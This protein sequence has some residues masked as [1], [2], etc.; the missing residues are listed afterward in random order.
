MFL[1]PLDSASPISL[2]LD[3]SWGGVEVLLVLLVYKAASMPPSR[4]CWQPYHLFTIATTGKKGD[5]LL[6]LIVI[7]YIS[8]SEGSEVLKVLQLL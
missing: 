7:N 6:L 1:P 8:F 4:S 3:P 5:S 2:L